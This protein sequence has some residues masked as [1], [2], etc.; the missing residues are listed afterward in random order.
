MSYSIEVNDELKIIFYKHSG[1][2]ERRDLGEVW[3]ELLG[4]KEFSEGGYNLYSDYRNGKLNLIDS[5]MEVISD[6]LNSI[7][8]ILKGKKESVLVAD[9]SSTAIALLYENDLLSEIGFD[10]KVFSTEKAAL[11]FLLK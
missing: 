3:K 7:N 10:V 2:I 5:D 11:N 1:L 6:F 9:N 8:H 4:I